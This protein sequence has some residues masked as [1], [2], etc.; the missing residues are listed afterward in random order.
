M[1]TPYDQAIAEILRE[2]PHNHNRYALDT[3]YG[4]RQGWL[5]AEEKYL[6][7]LKGMYELVAVLNM[8]A[9]HLVTDEDAALYKQVSHL[10]LTEEVKK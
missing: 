6:P 5:D 10:F 8:D 1:K 3:L 2:P 4:K 7:L 9:E